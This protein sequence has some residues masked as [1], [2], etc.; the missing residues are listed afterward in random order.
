MVSLHRDPGRRRPIEVLWGSTA[1]G[2]GMRSWWV[3][4]SML[5]FIITFE[6]LWPDSGARERLKIDPYGGFLKPKGVA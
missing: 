4:A 2:R 6:E 3:M 1:W 5:T